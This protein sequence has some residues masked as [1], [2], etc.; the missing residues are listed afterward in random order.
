MTYGGI[1]GPWRVHADAAISVAPRSPRCSVS[2]HRRGRRLAIWG[3]TSICANCRS[4]RSWSTGR[5]ASRPRPSGRAGPNYS[6]PA[7]MPGP[8]GCCAPSPAGRAWSLVCRL[9]P[10]GAAI[11]DLA[12]APD[13]RAIAS[14]GEDGRGVLVP[15]ADGVCGAPR[16]LDAQ[17]EALYSVR[18]SPDGAVLV[19]AS[20]DARAQ[21]WDSRGGALIDNDSTAVP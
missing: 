5:I 10:H 4:P 12:F 9:D 8:C 16:F 1:D 19:T 3:R 2:H 7:T 17:T 14:V 20:M 18:F 15:L 21:V 6:P 11:T 13:G